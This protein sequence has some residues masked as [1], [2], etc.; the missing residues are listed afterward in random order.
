MR[1]YIAAQFNLTLVSLDSICIYIY[2]YVYN[3]HLPLPSNLHEFSVS[4][5]DL[6][7]SFIVANNIVIVYHR[8]PNSSI[9]APGFL[10]HVLVIL[11]THSVSMLSN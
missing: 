8:Y 3:G 11:L 9:N 5:S 7:I 10:D 4:A 2:I 1:L 6:F